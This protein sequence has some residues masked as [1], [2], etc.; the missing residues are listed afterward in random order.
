MSRRRDLFVLLVFLLAFF[1]FFYLVFDALTPKSALD[2]LSLGG[3]S[4]VGLIQL[5]GPI[6]NSRPILDQLDKMEESS[7]IKAI[8]VRL[9]TP[10][11]GV[12]ASQEIYQKLA[13][14]RDE[15]NIPIIASMGGVAA[16][17]GYYISLG[18]DTIVANPGTTTGSIGVLAEIPVYGALLKKIGVEVEVIKSGKFKD[19]GSPHRALTPE[20]KK[21]LQGWVDDTYQQFVETVAAERGMDLQQVELLAD[22]RVYTGRQALKLG[23][24]D[25]LGSMDDALRIAGELGGITGKPRLVKLEKKKLTLL[26]FLLGDIE[27]IIFLQLG[28]AIPLKY[29]MPRT[30]P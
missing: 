16:S 30:F 11:G 2:D 14:L 21:Y 24:V 18:A 25:I 19:T 15:K 29:E 4:K 13:H 7:S 23:L 27:E 28:M 1:L 20:E 9:E 6:Y 3:G 22:G 5:I 8:L 26:D 12:A 10:G 17:G